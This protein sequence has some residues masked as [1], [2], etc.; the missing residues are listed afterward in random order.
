MS[1]SPT[2]DEHNSSDQCVHT[3]PPILTPSELSSDP[4]THLLSPKP[5]H[6]ATSALTT[7][8]IQKQQQQAEVVVAPKKTDDLE[9]LDDI[10]DIKTK[11]LSLEENDTKRKTN[12]DDKKTDYYSIVEQQKLIAKLKIE[13]NGRNILDLGANLTNNS[14]T[15]N[16]VWQQQNFMRFAHLPQNNLKMFLENRSQYHRLGANGHM[17][18]YA[19]VNCKCCDFIYPVNGY[20]NNNNNSRSNTSVKTNN[21]QIAPNNGGNVTQ[22]NDLIENIIANVRINEQQPQT[23]TRPPTK[24]PHFFKQQQQHEPTTFDNFTALN[25]SVVPNNQSNILEN[26]AAALLN[27]TNM[28]VLNQ[29][30]FNT[31][32]HHYNNNNNHRFGANNNY[33]ASYPSSY[34]YKQF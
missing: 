2:D 19:L 18:E 30:H 34:S 15:P 4:K 31:K 7:E 5:K 11:E 23:F 22:K 17:Q 32:A 28:H 33:H 1:S 16:N 21:G 25:R 29:T 8:N 26:I 3:P 24:N 27:T 20:N 6:A 9:K 12:E 14:I 13:I 10:D